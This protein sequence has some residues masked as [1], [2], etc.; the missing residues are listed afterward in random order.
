MLKVVEEYAPRAR[1]QHGDGT[2]HDAETAGYLTGDARKA[3]Y[4]IGLRDH[5]YLTHKVMP[6]YR[7][8]PREHHLY[9]AGLYADLEKQTYNGA[10]FEMKKSAQDQQEGRTRVINA[11]YK[12]LA[13][14]LSIPEVLDYAMVKAKQDKRSTEV[15]T[16][17]GDAM[18]FLFKFK[19]QNALPEPHSPELLEYL[20]VLV[21]Q[22]FG[23]PIKDARQQ[24]EHTVK[25]QVDK[26]ESDL[27]QVARCALHHSATVGRDRGMSVIDAAFES[28][29]NTIQYST[30]R[31]NMVAS[32]DIGVD[33]PATTGGASALPAI[34]AN[35]STHFNTAVPSGRRFGTDKEPIV[36][37]NY[38]PPFEEPPTREDYV[39]ILGEVDWKKKVQ[40][41]Q[42][43]HDTN[44]LATVML[45][46]TAHLAVLWS[47]DIPS[48]NRD[49]TNNTWVFVENNSRYITNYLKSET[50][51]KTETS[52]KDVMYNGFPLV[53]T[54]NANYFDKFCKYVV[55][56]Y[57]TK[58]LGI[59]RNKFM[60]RW[61][62]DAGWV[63][64][65]IRAHDFL[66]TETVGDVSDMLNSTLPG[67]PDVGMGWPHVSLLIALSGAAAALTAAVESATQT[68]GASGGA[69]TAGASGGASSNDGNDNPPL[70]LEEVPSVQDGVDRMCTVVD[71]DV[72]VA[73]FLKAAQ[74]LSG[75]VQGLN[76]PSRFQSILWD[77]PRFN[78]FNFAE[79][80]TIQNDYVASSKEQ[81]LPQLVVQRDH[82]IA[83]KA[84]AYCI[85][86]GL[87]G[88]NGPYQRKI[89]AVAS[90]L[91]D[92]VDKSWETGASAFKGMDALEKLV[93]SVP[94][95]SFNAPSMEQSLKDA[96]AAPTEKDQ[97]SQ[98][99]DS[100]AQPVLDFV[101]IKKQKDRK[102]DI[103][104]A[105]KWLPLKELSVNVSNKTSKTY[106]LDYSDVVC[107]ALSEVAVL[108]HLV[109]YYAANATSE[110][111]I[112]TYK[113]IH[114]MAC[115]A[116]TKI[117]QLERM[118]TLGKNPST[119]DT[120]IRHLDRNFISTYVAQPC[121]TCEGEGDGE[122]GKV[123]FPID[124]GY[125]T[126]YHAQKFQNRLIFGGDT[127]KS[128]MFSLSSTGT[129]DA[130]IMQDVYDRSDYETP[131][132]ALMQE[133]V[134][135]TQSMRAACQT[136]DNSLKLY[137]PL[138]VAKQFVRHVPK[139]W[140]EETT[141]QILPG[142]V[143][144]PNV[145]VKAS[146]LRMVLEN[147][148]KAIR[149]RKELDTYIE[150]IERD[151][152][153]N[154]SDF[155]DEPDSDTVDDDSA[156]EPAG[157]GGI[158]KKR[159]NE[160]KD[161]EKA[162]RARVHAIT[163]DALKEVAIS[164]DRL[165]TF[166]QQLS[167]T[168]SEPVESLCVIDESGLQRQ[169]RELRE[170][171]AKAAQRA[172]ETHMLVVRNIIGAILKDAQL[173][174]GVQDSKFTVASSTLKEQLQDVLNGPSSSSS[175][176]FTKSVDLDRILNKG[177]ED[178]SM[179]Q[180][181]K[182]LT[183][184]GAYIHEQ[185]NSFVS[186]DFSGGA[187]SLEYLRLPRNCL[188]IQWK[189]D[190]HAAIRRAYDIFQQEMRYHH[191]HMRHITAFELIEGAD[192]G[193]CN[194]FADFTGQVLVGT[195]LRNPTNAVYVSQHAMRLNG[196][197][198]RLALHRLVQAAC[199][200]V[201][202]YQ[203]PKPEPGKVVGDDPSTSKAWLAY[204][205]RACAEQGSHMLGMAAP[206][207]QHVLRQGTQNSERWVYTPPAALGF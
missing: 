182:Q 8:H 103:I 68:A 73:F 113:R 164:G 87:C 33:V 88:E 99:V 127:S 18:V 148:L 69:S 136:Q 179:E 114:S 116:A 58:I 203:A 79:D 130:Y 77:N 27:K 139:T 50:S 191:H 81:A 160:F 198:T 121:Y 60:D 61:T 186:K 4:G 78:L 42:G 125:Y 152:G 115:R 55:F 29:R 39:A 207:R 131:R 171:E 133:R 44:D 26:L 197:S 37:N 189:E 49:A 181:F 163:E 168:I 47:K 10:M 95:Q 126:V 161:F 91:L 108:E 101:Q 19:D 178:I 192:S 156:P 200:Y 56:A 117:L 28:G 177:D 144:Y 96:T 205:D 100:Q 118:Q 30:R 138:E 97:I 169:Q 106:A 6:L 98:E 129:S 201:R 183:T 128:H 143:N 147:G 141:F 74:F 7:P 71:G 159:R 1:K 63:P 185:S 166:V 155:S 43:W 93:Y 48:S 195:K 140:T 102:T 188:F 83:Q 11:S 194:Y 14:L 17:A 174:L 84:V 9:P 145:N 111:E 92:S 62:S 86:R 2:M 187:M 15:Q 57:T 180:L 158:G 105:A 85:A 75:K 80:A 67:Q 40:T 173:K 184:V 16:V 66:H 104:Q 199:R 34:W 90:S 51:L 22:L 172:A 36:P 3:R 64:F 176:F 21:L 82:N 165:W 124:A 135:L 123:L 137:A 23:S 31:E 65:V 109:D 122:D 119:A 196:E 35:S 41:M 142:V 157:C 24:Y 107:G 134:Q 190:A 120:N 70:L 38:Q 154:K 45:T 175:G 72:S 110:E 5:E 162:S 170:Q 52:L 76:S 94:A 12:T 204:F 202:F 150:R 32:T 46:I 112:A 25:T 149:K 151:L 132:S 193:L 89:N 20:F 53:G 59:E 13:S 153:Q 54:E 167:G 146:T 206:V